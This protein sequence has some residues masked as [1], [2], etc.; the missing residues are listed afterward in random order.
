MGECA[1]FGVFFF[2][3]HIKPLNMLSV[4]DQITWLSGY[5]VF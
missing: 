2:F 1:V 3:N 4:K 5:L